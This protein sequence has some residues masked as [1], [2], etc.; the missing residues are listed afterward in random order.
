[1]D[2]LDCVYVRILTTRAGTEGEEEIVIDQVPREFSI[3]TQELSSR[4]LTWI[5]TEIEYE[6]EREQLVP[7]R[8][9]EDYLNALKCINA[10]A[11]V[12]KATAQAA[13]QPLMTSSLSLPTGGPGRNWRCSRCSK[14]NEGTAFACTICGKPSNMSLPIYKC[15]ECSATVQSPD[16]LCSNCSAAKPALQPPKPMVPEAPV[17]LWKCRQCMTTNSGTA[18]QCKTCGNSR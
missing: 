17:E 12:L 11:L 16:S 13:P 5:Q 4:G 18:K 2:D 7:L 14:L 15:L 3:F 8:S 10:Q 9:K 6:N 1:M